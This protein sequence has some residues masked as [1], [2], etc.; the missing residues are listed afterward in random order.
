MRRAW[1]YPAVAAALATA[2]LAYG[3]FRATGTGSG[4]GASAWNGAQRPHH[5]RLHLGGHVRHLFPGAHKRMRV[6]IT[7]RYRDPLWVR[8]VSTVVRGGGPGC[9]ASNVRVH[10]YRGRFRIGAH[11]SR[12]L[13]LR[14]TMSGDA[15]DA[16]QGRRFKL[17]FRA[18]A[19]PR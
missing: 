18:R 9:P 11:R 15:P 12:R 5:P 6:T 4:P 10:R 7:S 1:V 17:R 2:A 8:S 16:C 19:S 13:R 14:V 3:E